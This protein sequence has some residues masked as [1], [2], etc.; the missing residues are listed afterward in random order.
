M[1]MINT[2]IH[3]ISSGRLMKSHLTCLAILICLLG[4]AG[5]QVERKNVDGAKILDYGMCTINLKETAPSDTTASGGY[6]ATEGVIFTSKTTNIPAEKGISFGIKYVVDGDPEGSKIKLKVVAIHPSIKGK[7][8]SSAMVD[9][10]A[11]TWRAD[12]Y[13][14][15]EDYELVEGE[16]IFQVYWKD[17]LLIDQSF[18]VSKP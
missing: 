13:T 16:W 2:F 8:R 18:T 6:N 7:I 12:F 11:G 9:A 14:F 5:S 10:K 1:R 17:N 4:C 3:Q 15:N